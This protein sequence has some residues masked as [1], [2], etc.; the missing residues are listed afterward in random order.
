MA[1]QTLIQM[2]R[3]RGMDSVDVRVSQDGLDTLLYVNQRSGVQ[4]ISADGLTLS[5]DPKAF[6]QSPARYVTEQLV[7]HRKYQELVRKE[8]SKV[9]GDLQGLLAAERGGEDALYDLPKEAAKPMMWLGKLLAAPSAWVRGRTLNGQIRE[10]IENNKTLAEAYRH[11]ESVIEYGRGF[12]E[13]RLRAGSKLPETVRT[14]LMQLKGVIEELSTIYSRLATA[15]D[16]KAQA[17]Q[18]TYQRAV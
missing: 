2:L 5:Y 7:A 10:N 15:A 17:G 4:R 11:I 13:E 6:E 1:N 16:R 18:R 12:V 3:S 8:L 14:E 9:S